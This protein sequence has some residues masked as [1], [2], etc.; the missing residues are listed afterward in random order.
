MRSGDEKRSCIENWK[1]T[2]SDG[3]YLRTSKSI[4][5]I[6]LLARTKRNRHFGDLLTGIIGAGNEAGKK[7]GG[8]AS[9]LI[10]IIA[11][12]PFV[13]FVIVIMRKMPMNRFLTLMSV[14]LLATS[15]FVVS[16]GPVG[17]AQSAPDLI[18]AFSGDLRGYLEECG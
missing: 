1:R 17:Q 15:L 6:I 10:R 16:G 2:D 14:A 3:R 5:A 13:R 8:C 7:V 11:C 18:V 4:D 9:F 12:R